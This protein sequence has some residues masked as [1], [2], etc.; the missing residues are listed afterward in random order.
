MSG[1]ASRRSAKAGCGGPT[2]YSW[3]CSAAAG[4][5]VEID[6]TVCRQN[7]HTRRPVAQPCTASV[8]QG[9]NLSYPPA[10]RA[11]SQ[12]WRH[13]SRSGRSPAFGWAGSTGCCL[14][15]RPQAGCF[16]ERRLQGSRMNRLVA[17]PSH[18]ACKQ[19]PRPA[20]ACMKAAQ[21]QTRMK[22]SMC[23]ASGAPPAGGGGRQA[24]RVRMQC[25]HSDLLIRSAN[26]P[27]RCCEPAV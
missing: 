1:T 18:Q 10:C 24:N 4:N 17:G 27:S 13:T 22:S 14:L 23:C 25:T 3:L 20:L 9:L 12:T 21:E 8:Q 11:R 2:V 26:P 5:V 15:H 6:T 19:H 7:V 16:L